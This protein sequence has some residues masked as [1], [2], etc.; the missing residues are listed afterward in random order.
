MMYI[1]NLPV[2]WQLGKF[3]LYCNTFCLKAGGKTASDR[4]SDDRHDPFCPWRAAFLCQIPRW[5]QWDPDN[6]VS[7]VLSETLLL[8]CCRRM[9]HSLRWLCRKWW[10][11]MGWDES[12]LASVGS[13]GAGELWHWRR[14]SA[15]CT[16]R[17]LVLFNLHSNNLRSSSGISFIISSLIE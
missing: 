12:F 4:V 14:L 5:W 11:P 2:W 6:L 13:A 16:P 10:S 7:A 17:N 9:Q 1:M 8:S 3:T 15:T